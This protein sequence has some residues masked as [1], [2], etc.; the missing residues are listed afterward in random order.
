MAS[1]INTEIFETTYWQYI[2]DYDKFSEQ[3][4]RHN[5]SIR[6]EGRQEGRK[7]GR[8]DEKYLIAKNMKNLGVNSDI[9]SQATG[10]EV[11][12]IENL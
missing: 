3:L 9:I 11:K 4:E 6:K 8:L 5:N 2:E 7:E 1:R 10:L 12:E